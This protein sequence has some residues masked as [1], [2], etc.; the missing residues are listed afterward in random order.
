[1]HGQQ[2]VKTIFNVQFSFHVLTYRTSANGKG[3]GKG[4]SKGK[5]KGKSKVHPRTGHEG[6]E[7]GVE[8]QLYSFSRLSAGW[9]RVVNATLWPRHLLQWPHPVSIIQEAR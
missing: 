9:E 8:V 2:N 4:K 3:K 1:M 7:R 5:G 6:L